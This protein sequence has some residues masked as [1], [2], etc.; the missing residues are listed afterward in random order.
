MKTIPWLKQRVRQKI[1]AQRALLTHAEIKSKSTLVCQRILSLNEFQNAKDIA[2]YV[3]FSGEIDCHMLFEAA[4]KSHK[5]CYLP[6][7]AHQQLHFI[8]VDDKTPLISN[9]FGILEPAFESQRLIK[10]ELF[11]LVIVPLVAFDK[12]C[13]RLGMGKGYYDRTFH[14][15]TQNTGPTL[16]GVAYEFQKLLKVPSTTLDVPLDCVVT[17]KKIYRS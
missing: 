1:C 5:N 12:S 17:E 6:V 4:L 3:A 15:K 2:L 7:L 10:P 14:F 9:R 13:H 8:Q 11:D 16:V